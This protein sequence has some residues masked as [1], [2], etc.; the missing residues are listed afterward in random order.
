M[1]QS[2]NRLKYVSRK[3]TTIIKKFGNWISP[4]S[5]FRCWMKNTLIFVCTF[6]FICL[7]YLL[8]Q[9]KS[10]LSD[11]FT[12]GRISILKG[13]PANITKDIII[14]LFSLSE[15][16]GVTVLTKTLIKDIAKKRPNWRLLILTSKKR[17]NTY[18]YLPQ[19]DNVKRIEVDITPS[20]LVYAQFKSQWFGKLQDK[21]T[22]LIQYDCLFLDSHC[23]LIWDP[24]GDCSLCNFVTV[25]RI[26]T[27]HD[28][29]CFNNNPQSEIPKDKLL[30]A[31]ATTNSINFSKK[32]ITVSEFS[33]KQI[34]DEFHVSKDFVKHIPI[35]LGMRVY[36]DSDFEKSALVLDKY[37][38]EFQKYFIFCSA[39][40]KNKNHLNL[41]KAFNKFAQKN[42]DIKL[43]LVGYHRGL[44][45]SRPISE[46]ES[47]RLIIT[48]TVPDEDLGILLKNALAF[49]H[50]SVYEGF[51]M[52]IIEAMTNGIPVACSNVTSL[53][54]IAGPAA[55][56]FD[57][58]NVDSITQALHRLADDPLLRKD[59]IQK[60]YE[61][62]KKYSDRDSMVD[63][64]IRIMEEVMKGNNH[65]R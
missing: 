33:Q 53:P 63:E 10:S 34:C 4:N 31:Y 14:D 20:P 40:W 24:I 5:T 50:P 62:A 32:I 42:S 56:L 38:L 52:P 29:A 55:L 17:R 44:F 41:I 35:K 15:R 46:F 6:F 61:Q 9:T 51:G 8:I 23:D 16:G 58:F 64:Y 3:I 39:W 54:E 47:D 45:K 60:G 59:L 2:K 11:V 30:R 21:L 12:T 22:Q 18:D 57:P 19:S 36:S 48:G 7:T 37:R 27:I 65:P 26:S 28:L 25:P 1:N 43:I 13:R 49:I